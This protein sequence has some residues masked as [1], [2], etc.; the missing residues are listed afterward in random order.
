MAEQLAFARDAV[1]R[2]AAAAREAPPPQPLETMLATL[3]GRLLL[4]RPQAELVIATDPRI[5]GRMVQA[6]SALWGSLGHLLE[7]AADAG[8]VAGDGRLELH[9]TPAD[10]AGLR[11]SLRDRGA[12][13]D[14]G[15]H[16]FV[17]SSKA[18]GLGLGFAIANATVELA[19]GRLR[20]RSVAGGGTLSEL[21]LP[22][23]ALAPRTESHR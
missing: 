2:L 10:A 6:S 15:A 17:A 21:E 22:W 13:F 5:A 11:L 14:G 23:S 19:G 20:V 8:L 3:R 1:R 18:D 7:N 9:A 4:L 12:G 16:G